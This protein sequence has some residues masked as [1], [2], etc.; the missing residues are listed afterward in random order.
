[1]LYSQTKFCGNFNRNLF[2]GL[3]VCFP[4]FVEKF[5]ILGLTEVVSQLLHYEIDIL[6]YAFF[7]SHIYKPKFLFY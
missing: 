4:D 6:N 3:P 7:V 1:M 5:N 2:G